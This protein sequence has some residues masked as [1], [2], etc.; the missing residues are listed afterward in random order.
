M[1]ATQYILIIGT[2]WPEPN[3]S[4]AGGRMLQ[5][6]ELFVSKAWKV[7][8]A[9]AAADSEYMFDLNTLN[10]DKVS[11][12]LNNSSFDSFV[13]DLKPTIVLFDRFMTE[14]QFGWRVAEHCPDALR[15]LDTEDLHCLRSARQ[16][17]FKENRIFKNDDLICDIAK[18]EIA[19]VLRCDLSLIIS[20]FSNKLNDSSI[21]FSILLF[22]IILPQ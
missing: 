19:S 4:A 9:S 22:V 8:F 1:S 17:T 13:S 20:E 3:S 21:S 10:I 16:L 2:V 7:T 5:L 18:R 15:I 14:E 6:I 11:I 12:E